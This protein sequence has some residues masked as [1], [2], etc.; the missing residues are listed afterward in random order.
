MDQTHCKLPYSAP[1]RQQ[2]AGGTHN[3]TQPGQAKHELL[4]KRMRTGS[5]VTRFVRFAAAL[6]GTLPI[7]FFIPIG[8]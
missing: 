3:E 8:H 1:L 2:A 7:K 4:L 5:C 6:Q